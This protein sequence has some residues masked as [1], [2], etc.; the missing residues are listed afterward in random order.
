MRTWA[1]LFD[2]TG[3]LRR[4]ADRLIFVQRLERRVSV[5]QPPS[6]GANRLMACH[7][8]PCQKG[9][10][11]SP[12]TMYHGIMCCHGLP[13]PDKLDNLTQ[14]LAS[15]GSTDER[16]H[17]QASAHEATYLG[18]RW[19]G[20]PPTYSLDASASEGV[21]TV[22]DGQTDCRAE[23]ATACDHGRQVV[24]TSSNTWPNHPWEEHGERHASTI[25]GTLGQGAVWWSEPAI[26]R[27]KMPQQ[28]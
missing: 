8:S 19:A 5:G 20:F 14:A 27:L 22:S 23:R 2:V 18:D 3:R 15:H 11:C 17:R 1:F 9:C 12:R 16:E 10:F 24:S 7:S 21:V 25:F 26:Y 28:A 13:L 6:G 4:T